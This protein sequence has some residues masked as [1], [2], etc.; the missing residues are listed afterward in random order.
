MAKKTILVVD[1]DED[2]R[3]LCQEVLGDEG[4]EI[5]V[6]RDG[7]EALE[8]VEHRIPDLVVLDIV[9]PEMDGMEAMTRILRKHKK[10]PVILNTSYSRFREDFLTGAADAY[11]VK[12]SDLTELKKKIRELISSSP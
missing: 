6:A 11:V 2:Q 7:K 5:M 1:D 4:Y 9:M 12:S 3:L 8:R 10:I